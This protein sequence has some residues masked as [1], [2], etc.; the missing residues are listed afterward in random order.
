MS[1]VIDTA[2]PV[3]HRRLVILALAV[4]CAVAA[5]LLSPRGLVADEVGENSGIPPTPVDEFVIPPG[6]EELLADM[7]GRGATL[8]GQ[9]QLSA[10][11]INGAIVVG[12]YTC[13][14]G[15]VV[16]ELRHPS[17]APADASHTDKFAVVVKSG[18]PPAGLADALLTSIKSH[19]AQ[20]KWL[21]LRPPEAQASHGFL[22][23][24]IPVLG[25]AAV[26]FVLRRMRRAR[27]SA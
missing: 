8:P 23:T 20:F 26:I 5:P 24:L 16:F 14:A 12:T 18:A 27:R 11:D 21:S 3:A 19:E 13:P 25:V 17:K 2:R 4:C 6:Q 9:C 7:L 10:G 15:Q 22:S 1:K